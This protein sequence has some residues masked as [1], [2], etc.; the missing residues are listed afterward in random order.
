MS[1]SS[2]ERDSTLRRPFGTTEQERYVNV[3]TLKEAQRPELHAW[4]E[5]A[6]RVPG[7]K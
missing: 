1:S 2:A 6:G 7:W 4:I 3:T 5:Q